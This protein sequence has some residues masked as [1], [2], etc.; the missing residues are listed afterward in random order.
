MKSDPRVEAS[1]K[2]RSFWLTPQDAISVRFKFLCVL[3]AGPFAV[4]P[5][6]EAQRGFA[7]V[8]AVLRGCFSTGPPSLQSD[9]TPHPPPPP[10]Q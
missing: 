4:V 1:L 10:P 7:L 9:S 2:P 8:A 3:P 6:H 5:K